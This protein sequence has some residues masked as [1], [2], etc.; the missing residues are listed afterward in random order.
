MS[1][2]SL[3]SSCTVLAGTYSCYILAKNLTVLYSYIEKL[4]EAELKNYRL[5]C[6]EEEMSR[7]F[8]RGWYG[9]K[10]R[11]PTMNVGVT[12]T[13]AKTLGQNAKWKILMSTNVFSL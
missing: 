7:Q 10:E 4:N 2:Y 9:A 3:G 5:I 8:D 6:K 12:I 1:V 11:G 13:L